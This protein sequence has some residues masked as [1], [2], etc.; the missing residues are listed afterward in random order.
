MY[1]AALA[2]LF[3]FAVS[4]TLRTL[5][6]PLCAALPVGTHY[7]WHVL[8]GV[9]LYLVAKAATGTRVAPLSSKPTFR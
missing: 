6:E 7:L 2:G 1:P 3:V 9:T 8:N 4:L 5:D